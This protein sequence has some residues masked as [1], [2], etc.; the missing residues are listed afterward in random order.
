MSLFPLTEKTVE[1][2]GKTLTIRE[3]TPA[4]RKESSRLRKSED[5]EAAVLHMV[6]TCVVAPR[7]TVDDL[8]GYPVAVVDEL[9]SAILDLNGLD[10]PDEKND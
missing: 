8:R 7:M 1:I 9:L 2:R 3:W 6:A 10:E 4:E 5:P